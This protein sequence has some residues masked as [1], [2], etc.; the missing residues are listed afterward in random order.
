MQATECLRDWKAV[1][2][3]CAVERF[4]N[5]I[6]SC[7][8]NAASEYLRRKY[9]H[10]RRL[11]DRIHYLL[12][13]D[14]RLAVWESAQ[15]GWLCGL[16][17]WKG[18]DSTAPLTPPDRWNEARGLRPADSLHTIFQLAGEPVEFDALVRRGSGAGPA[19]TA[20]QVSGAGFQQGAT[21]G[22]PASI[23]RGARH[24]VRGCGPAGRCHAGSLCGGCGKSRIASRTAAASQEH[25]S[26]ALRIAGRAFRSEPTCCSVVPCPRTHRF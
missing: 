5:Y 20:R 22:A 2:E 19:F 15:S 13:H 10:W 6:A 16:S 25:Q 26:S 9:P 18:Q 1:T 8:F 4:A 21:I 3:V 23:A 17:K 24:C 7:S 12:R 11:R 14:S